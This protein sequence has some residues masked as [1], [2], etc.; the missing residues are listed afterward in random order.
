MEKTLATD[1]LDTPEGLGQ[2]LAMAFH[3]DRTV[4]GGF[5]SDEAQKL[6]GFLMKGVEALVYPVTHA[7]Q[8]ARQG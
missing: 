4:G 1:N 7:A 3:V 8:L 6:L 2:V 5:L